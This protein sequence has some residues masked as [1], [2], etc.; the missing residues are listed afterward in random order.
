MEELAWNKEVSD[1]FENWFELSDRHEDCLEWLK[2]GSKFAPWVD[3]GESLSMP[4][5]QR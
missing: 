2:Y 4:L 5:W 1:M 3:L